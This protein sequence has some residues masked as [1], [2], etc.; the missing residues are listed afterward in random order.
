MGDEKQGDCYKNKTSAIFLKL[1]QS[2]HTLHKRCDREAVLSCT[3]FFFFFFSFLQTWNIRSHCKGGK[4]ATFANWIMR[5]RRISGMNRIWSHV[6]ELKAAMFV[7]QLKMWQSR[8]E[9]RQ[10]TRGFVSLR[11]RLRVSRCPPIAVAKVMAQN[12]DRA[13]NTLHKN[14]V[15]ADS[16]THSA[17]ANSAS[18]Y[19][20]D[21]IYTQPI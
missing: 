6:Q 5:G 14:S 9:T 13:S 21:D 20:L 7:C 17:W 3:F 18:S 2:C 8:H 10:E 15:S 11:V 16:R 12:G 19:C 1:S 4:T